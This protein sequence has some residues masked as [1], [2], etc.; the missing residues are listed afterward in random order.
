MAG[1]AAASAEA[2]AKRLL[3]HETRSA[4]RSGDPRLAVFAVC[5]KLRSPLVKLMGTSGFHSLLSRALS[6]AGAKSPWLRDLTI[7]LD[8]SL[9]GL[10]ESSRS[11]SQRARDVGEQAVTK[12]FLRLLVTF[13][14]PTLTD[15]LIRDIWPKFTNAGFRTRETL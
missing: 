3:A 7:A 5:D 9:S 4:P 15:Q 14:G 10:E 6:I 1:D 2:L 12:E 13:I 11:L 8:G